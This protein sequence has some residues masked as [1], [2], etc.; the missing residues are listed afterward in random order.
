MAEIKLT[1]LPQA[2]E[3]KDEDIMILEQDNVTKTIK[4][5][6]IKAFSSFTN[7]YKKTDIDSNYYKKVDVDTKIANLPNVKVQAYEP[8]SPTP[9]NG[10][11]WID[12]TTNTLKYR[13]NNVWIQLGAVYS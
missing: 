8:T 2:T 7:Y 13:W 10:D 6:N 1:Q 4:F 3:L 9:K 5:G 11:I 12:A